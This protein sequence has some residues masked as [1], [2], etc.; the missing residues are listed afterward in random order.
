[1][2]KQDLLPIIFGENVKALRE[3][4]NLSQED[5]G[6]LVGVSRVS[7]YAYENERRRPPLDVAC[8]MA[9]I[10][11]VSLDELIIVKEG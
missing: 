8:K 6:E 10:L 7:I 11:G 5:F 2:I 1:M 4:K 9:K 3:S